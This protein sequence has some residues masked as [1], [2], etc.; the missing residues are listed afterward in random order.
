MSVGKQKSQTLNSVTCL[1]GVMRP[2]LWGVAFWSFT[3]DSV[4]QKFPSEARV[5]CSGLLPAVGTLYCLSIPIGAARAT[6]LANS[7][8][9]PKAVTS[10]V[11]RLIDSPHLVRHPP[12]TLCLRNISSVPTYQSVRSDGFYRIGVNDCG[13]RSAGV[14][15][16]TMER[17][18]VSVL[19]DSELSRRKV[20]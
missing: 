19:P 16:R 14:G 3:K 18:A 8:A 17:F 9:T 13:V 11:T 15:I 2:T 1:V 20:P 12:P 4:N 7:N 5:M 6:P 10:S